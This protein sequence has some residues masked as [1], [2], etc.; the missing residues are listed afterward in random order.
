VSGSNGQRSRHH[1]KDN[2][3]LHQIK[4]VVDRRHREKKVGGRKRHEEVTE[5]CRGH[6]G[7]GRTPAVD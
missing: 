2:Q 5:Y 4:E 6:K 1:D 7:E 3:V